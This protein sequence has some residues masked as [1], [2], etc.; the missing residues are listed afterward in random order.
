MTCARTTARPASPQRG[1][2][3]RCALACLALALLAGG[4]AAQRDQT[5][6]WRIDPY[7]RND[8]RL[9]ERLGY[10][11]YGPF[12]FG[13]RGTKPVTTTDIDAHLEDDQILWVETAHFKIGMTLEEWVVPLDPPIKAKIRAELTEL[14]ER[15]GISRINPK[16]R[17]LDRWLR[18]HLFAQ[19]LE[20]HYARMSALL[21]VTDD[22]FPKDPE[23]RKQWTGQYAGEGPFLGQ[24]GKY[25]F[26][27]F[28]RDRDYDDYLASFTGRRT[29]GGQQ[30][31]FIEVD[32][33]FYGCS[34]DNPEEDGRLRDDTAMHGHVMHAATHSLLNGYL[35]YNYD[36]PVWIREGLA[37]WFEREVSPRFNSYTRGEG[38]AMFEA[39]KWRFDLEA[40]SMAANDDFTPMSEAM[41][42]RDFGQMDFEDHVALWSRWDYLLTFGQEKFAKFMRMAKGQIDPISGMLNGDVL[43]GTREAL[44]EAYGLTPL[45][46]D[47]RWKAWA[48]ETYPT[49]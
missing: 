23:D 31:N 35:H 27:L 37:H 46:L 3:V 14:Q 19:R 4:A 30:W 1:R 28:E 15:S 38:A 16:T 8:P 44:R 22:S 49:R 47:E 2:S 45:T 21:G 7:T 40:R 48:L 9:M 20:K 41:Q 29:I 5:P 25:L 13:Q 6:R 42:W 32:S 39:S 43:D 36:M 26:L 34:A 11:S 10:V 17:K 12:E 24:R 18:L 33:L